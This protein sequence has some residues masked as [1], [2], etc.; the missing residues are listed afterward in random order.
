MVKKYI[1][2]CG[3]EY[4]QFEIP[5]QLSVVMGEEL[6]ERTIRLLRENGIEDI[7]ISTNNPIFEKFGVPILKHNNLYV[8]SEDNKEITGQ[9]FDAFY[10]TEEPACYIF[11]DVYF[12]PEAIKKIVETETDDIELF[13]SKK[14]F[15]ENYLKTHEEPFALKVNNQKHLREAIEKSRELDKLH[16]FWRKPIVWELFTVIKNAPLQTKRDEYTTDYVGISDYTV[17]IDRPEDVKNLNRLLGGIKMIKCEVIER[18]TLGRFGELKNIVRA[19]NNNNIGELYVGD[20][21]ECEEDLAEY[22]MGNNDKKKIVVKV[23]EYKPEMKEEEK[24]IEKLG[25][26]IEN[27]FEEE[28]DKYLKNVKKEKKTSKKRISKK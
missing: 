8:V 13:G 6:V 2:M 15:A 25:E 10:P 1:I 23:V 5:R 28:K 26:E 3:G 9:W 12:S 22:L 14:P 11:G 19:T 17:D 27:Y 18:F 21:F 7:A 4:K 20:T 24:K 16:K